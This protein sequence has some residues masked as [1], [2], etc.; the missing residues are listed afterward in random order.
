MNTPNYWLV[1]AN[2]AGNDQAEA[3]Y[4]RGYWEMGYDDDEKPT[5][6]KRRNQIK[7]GDRIALKA[8]DG[9]GATTITIKAIGI[10]KDIANQKI[11]IDWKLTDLNRTVPSHGAFAT[12]HGPY[13]FSESWI[14]EV[15]CL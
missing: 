11:F 14:Q 9:H 13:S 15:F 2:W 3:F 1:G 4:L 5:L 10:V 12:I 8:M 6:T 7:I